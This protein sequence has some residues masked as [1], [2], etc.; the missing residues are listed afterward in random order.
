[1]INN[2]YFGCT[3]SELWVFIIVHTEYVTGTLNFFEYVQKME[4]E[5]MKYLSDIV[6]ILVPLGIDVITYTL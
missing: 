1:M 5:G 6:G 2:M 3:S 4:L